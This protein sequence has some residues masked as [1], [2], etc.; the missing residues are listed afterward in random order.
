MIQPDELIELFI[1]GIFLLIALAVITQLYLDI[2]ITKLIDTTIEV[3][4]PIFMV[5]FIASIF[6]NI[7]SEIAS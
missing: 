5:L 6:A 2:N 4:V 1:S 3:A 7:T